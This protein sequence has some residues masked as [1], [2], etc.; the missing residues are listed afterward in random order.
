MDDFSIYG[1]SFDQCLHHLELILKYC[2]RKNLTLNWKKCHFMITYEIILGHQ[3]SR[4]GTEMDRAKID[5]IV[6]LSM[7]KCVKD[8]RSFLGH[9]S[10]YRKFIKDISKIAKPMT[11]FLA[12]DVSFIFDK[13]CI[14]YWEKLK[15][16]II[17]APIIFAPD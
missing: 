2:A 6:K 4:K 7:L 15:K 16:E 13:E 12:K 9:A 11:N 14:N 10:F 17:S 5:V 3:I 8:I 1:D